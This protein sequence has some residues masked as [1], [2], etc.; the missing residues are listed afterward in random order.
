MFS[1]LLL[2]LGLWLVVLSGAFLIFC[3]ADFYFDPIRLWKSPKLYLLQ[4]LLNISS[5][6]YLYV[7]VG[8]AA[9]SREGGAATAREDPEGNR[10]PAYRARPQGQ[11]ASRILQEAAG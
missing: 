6:F 9:T 10:H 8:V 11:E 3:V 4:S 7:S 5:F 2:S 1:S